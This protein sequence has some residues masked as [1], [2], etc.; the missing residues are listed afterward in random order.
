MPPGWPRCDRIFE[1]S[2]K[3]RSLCKSMYAHRGRTGAFSSPRWGDGNSQRIR[4]GSEVECEFQ[5]GTALVRHRRWIGVWVSVKPEVAQH[6]RD[7][8]WVVDFGHHAKFAFALRA[9]HDV[10]GKD[11]TE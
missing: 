9:G 11:S 6:G 7:G 5:L 4:S 2:E 1:A 10:D 8:S 3:K